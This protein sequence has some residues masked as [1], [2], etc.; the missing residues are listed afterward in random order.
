MTPRPQW[1]LLSEK[2]IQGDARGI[3]F[4]RSKKMGEDL[5]LVFKKTDFIHGGVEDSEVR[6]K[7]MEKWQEG[8]SGG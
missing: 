7:A 4:V 8:R 1:V 3:L 6:L 5:M 2:F